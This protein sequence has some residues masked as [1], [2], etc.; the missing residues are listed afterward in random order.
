MKSVGRM[1]RVQRRSVRRKSRPLKTEMGVRIQL[2]ERNIGIVMAVE[3]NW[4]TRRKGMTLREQ[5][6][7]NL[8]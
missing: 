3:M 4:A 2:I 8:Y 7:S 5:T 6:V 1:V